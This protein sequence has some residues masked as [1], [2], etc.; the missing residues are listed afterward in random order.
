MGR[1]H[2][3]GLVF[4]TQPG[5]VM[6]PRPASERLVAVALSLLGGRPAVVADV[7]TGSGALGLVI[8]R[9]APQARVWATDT[10]PAAVALAREN[11][12]RLGLGGRV[13]VC[14]GD[15]LEPIPGCVDLVVANLPY[16]PARER[17]LHP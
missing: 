3:D 8:A 6:T 7:G 1:A 10:S 5:V 4:V 17:G 16:L 15:L 2:F 12:R 13:I 14:E 9:A 11:V